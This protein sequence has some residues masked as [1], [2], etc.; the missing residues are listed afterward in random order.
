MI[1]IQTEYE[2]TIQLISPLR[3]TCALEPFLTH[4]LITIPEANKYPLKVN[5]A[6]NRKGS[7]ESGVS[8]LVLLYLS[9]A[10]E[11]ID[12]SLGQSRNVFGVIIISL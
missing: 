6:S 2:Y 5:S 8:L 7:S 11:S 9:T 3:S 1:L 10:F 4:F 12:H